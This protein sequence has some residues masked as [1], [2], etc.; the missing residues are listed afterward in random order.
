MNSNEGKGTTMNSRLR[1]AREQAGL[2]QGQVAKMLG[3]HRPTIS[4]IEAGRRKVSAEEIKEFSRI[5]DVGIEWLAGMDDQPDEFEDRVQLVA[6][7]L[8]KLK[9]EDLERLRR[10]LVT[11]RSEATQ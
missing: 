2:S 3:V 7:E 5:Y 9:P 10:I 1:L 6:R 11:L 8:S 4:E